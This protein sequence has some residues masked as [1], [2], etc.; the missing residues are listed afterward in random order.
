MSAALK[1]PLF[2]VNF[3]HFASDMI[4]VKGHK[5]DVSLS[6]ILLLIE[7]PFSFSRLDSI[8]VLDDIERMFNL[9][10]ELPLNRAVVSLKYLVDLLLFEETETLNDLMHEYADVNYQGYDEENDPVYKRLLS[11]GRKVAEAKIK[12][13]N[14]QNKKRKAGL[15]FISQHLP[16]LI[17]GFGALERVKSAEE[18]SRLKERIGQ[19]LSGH[20]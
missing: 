12:E 4:K 1:Q 7:A 8:L 2:H 18:I 6:P 13:I 19:V 3:S 15:E 10:K 16:D 14:T 9:A 11:E 17:N 5:V 20:E